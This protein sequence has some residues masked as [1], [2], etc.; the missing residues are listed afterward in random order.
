MLRALLFV[1]V[2]CSVAHAADRPHLASRGEVLA[3]AKQHAQK[4]CP[5]PASCKFSVSL[6]D[7]GWLV[8]VVPVSTASD[9]TTSYPV[10]GHWAYLYSH[11][12]KFLREIPGL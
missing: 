12:G 11:E 1:L 5:K 6:D 4:S 7:E 10:G 8:S 2:L 9:G 3:L